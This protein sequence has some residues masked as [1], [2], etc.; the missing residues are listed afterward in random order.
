MEVK[1]DHCHHCCLMLSFKGS[2][3]YKRFHPCYN[4]SLVMPLCMALFTLIYY[5]ELQIL[6][7]LFLSYTRTSAKYNLQLCPL[8]LGIIPYVDRLS[9]VKRNAQLLNPKRLQVCY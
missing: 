8:V 3:R 6:L 7:L 4:Q 1:T 2:L 9:G 5:S